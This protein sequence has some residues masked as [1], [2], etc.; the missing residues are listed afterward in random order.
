MFRH[1]GL[2]H[3]ATLL[4][5]LVAVLLI[6][7]KVVAAKPDIAKLELRKISIS[8][9]PVSSFD[10]R[11]SSRLRFGKLRWLGG[12]TLSSSSPYFGGFSGL[13]IGPKG[14]KMAAVSDA[15][16]WLTAR[17]RYRGTQPLGITHARVGPLRARDGRKLTGVREIDAEGM[18]LITGTPENGQA[19]IT[20]ERLHRI[21]RYKLNGE[22]VVGPTSYLR[23]PSYVK[24]LHDNRGI[25][26]ITVLKGGRRKGTVV[27]FAEGRR[28]K[29][30]MLR[31]WLLGKRG[32]SEVFLNPIGGFD[33]TDIASLPS[34]GLIL[35][36]RR[37]RWTE[38][39][40]MRLRRIGPREIRP[41]AVM[42]GEVLFEADQRYAIDNMEGVAVHRSPRGRT[43]ITLISDDNFKFF[44]RTIL[45]Q[46]ELAESSQS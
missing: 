7:P 35:L 29:R 13:A 38:G 1:Y 34:G 37:F 12:L 42:K 21:G 14:E 16:F 44:Q 22:G 10:G 5:I 3:R 28:D 31:G 27:A 45:L 30:G 18:S 24:S 6:S 20:F 41:G 43:V 23:L 46:F 40:K 9:S 33:I 19:F 17:I 39:V 26:A 8:A 25:E 15:G 2:T 11:D 36:E 4:A 32:A